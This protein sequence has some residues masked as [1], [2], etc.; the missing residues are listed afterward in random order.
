MVNRLVF[1]GLLSISAASL[2]PAAKA[3]E[4]PEGATA[5]FNGDDLEGWHG[6]AHFSPYDLEAMSEEDRV[7]KRTTD[8]EDLKTHWTIENGELVNDGQGVY[9]TTDRD[10]GDIEFWI[11]Y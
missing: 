8:L 5:I 10:Y 9:A 3:V 1:I 6:M 2:C 11:D 4:V 7:A